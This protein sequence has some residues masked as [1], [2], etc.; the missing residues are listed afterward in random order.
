MTQRVLHLARQLE[1]RPII[2]PVS[3]VL[4]RTFGGT[5]D[6]DAWLGLRR[7]A[8]EHEPLAVRDWSRGDF[9]AEFTAKPWWSP[10]RLWFAEAPLAD[11]E[12]PGVIGAVAL[13]MRD[14]KDAGRLRDDGAD[15]ALPVL[16]WLM[17]LPEWRRRGIGRVLLATL[18]AACWDAGHR[19]I[20][21]ETHAA[22]SVALEF[23][24]AMGY[25]ERRSGFP[26]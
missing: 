1:S 18:E 16:H 26:A 4:L 25:A 6:I 21:L 14:A 3:G 8:F 5:D 12:K 9:H 17:V 2:E 10:E 13:A 15:R 22:W 7:R 24:R 20:G 11:G 19:H 23:Y